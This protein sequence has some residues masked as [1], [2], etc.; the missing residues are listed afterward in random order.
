MTHQ[1]T[2]FNCEICFEKRT[3]ASAMCPKFERYGKFIC[4]TCCFSNRMCRKLRAYEKGEYIILQ[5][6]LDFFDNIWKVTDDDMYD[7]RKFH[8]QKK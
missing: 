6:Q 4:H 2:E 5:R 1:M 3:I 8:S 7:L